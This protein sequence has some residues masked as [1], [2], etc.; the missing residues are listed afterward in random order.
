MEIGIHTF[1]SANFK[2][3][4]GNQILDEDNAESSPS[5]TMPFEKAVKYLKY[6]AT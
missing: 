2:D 4:D 5:H 1:A 3:D 6:L